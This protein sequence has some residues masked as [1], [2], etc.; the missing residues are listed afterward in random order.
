MTLPIKAESPKLFDAIARRYDLINRIIS[1]GMDRGW[2]QR[3]IR[4]LPT[5]TSLEILDLASG[6]GHVALVLAKGCTRIKSV[7]GIDLSQ[8]MLAVGRHKILDC[9]LNGTIDLRTG[10][11]QKLKFPDGTFDAV[12]V[13]CGLR[14]MPNLMAALAESYRVLKPGG[15]LIILELTCPS[16]PFFKIFHKIYLRFVMPIWGGIL[17][18]SFSAY[19]YLN[20]TIEAFPSGERFALIIRQTGFKHV[21]LDELSLGAATI[22]TA[23]K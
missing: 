5:G 7:L 3:M 6:T 20:V 4:H 18:G 17:A 9:K 12:T 22:Y 11:A 8:E 2:R 1:F 16:N 15:R 21:I 19:R 14:N 10:D 13:G 23:E